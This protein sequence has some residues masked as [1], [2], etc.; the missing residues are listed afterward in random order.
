MDRITV[1]KNLESLNFAP[2]AHLGA[3]MEIM[4]KSI[5]AGQMPGFEAGLMFG[6][7]M[8]LAARSVNGKLMLKKMLADIEL[9]QE[10]DPEKEKS[11]KTDTAQ[12]TP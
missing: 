2:E 12:V 6:V 8:T 4:D 3:T 1:D 7:T 5:Q 10:T 11:D 9:Q